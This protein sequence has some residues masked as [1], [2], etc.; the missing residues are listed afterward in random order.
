MPLNAELK[1][2]P[3]VIVMDDDWASQNG[4]R[5]FTMHADNAL[6]GTLDSIKQGRT[7]LASDV[8]FSPEGVRFTLTGGEL[9][10][11]PE[12]WDHAWRASSTPVQAF[13]WRDVT[14]EWLSF[15]FGYCPARRNG[16]RPK[17]RKNR[18]VKDYLVNTVHGLRY[19]HEQ[20]TGEEISLPG[21]I[22]QVKEALAEGKEGFYFPDNV[23][24]I[25]PDSWKSS[26][27][28]RTEVTR[29]RKEA[30]A[31]GK[32]VIKRGRPKGKKTNG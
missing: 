25:W 22:E 24:L 31:K 10:F 2:K 19:L 16:Q 23:P 29:D 4:P 18:M 30:L 15:M 9:S 21:A 13:R 20:E 28:L 12:Y 1:V 7:V 17:G 32:G 3:V 6:Y 14:E 8:K 27:T 5:T 11:L 26:D